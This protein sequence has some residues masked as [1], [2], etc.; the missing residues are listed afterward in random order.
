[1]SQ[2]GA[3]MSRGNVKYRLLKAVNLT[4]RFMLLDLALLSKPGRLGLAP[5]P[6]NGAPNK[7]L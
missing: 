1:M 2:N 6:P 7:L 4:G 3:N 5:A